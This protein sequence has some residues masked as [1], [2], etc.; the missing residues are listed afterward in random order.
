MTKQTD[1]DR[2][3]KILELRSVWGTGGGPEKTILLGAAKSNPKKYRITVC[4]IRDDRDKVF[5]P[6]NKASGL[7][8]D[9]VEIRERHSFDVRILTKLRRLCVDRRIQ[10]V[11]SH[12]Y[13]TN[14]LALLLSKL[15]HIIP[16]STAHGWTGYSRR[17]KVYYAIDKVILKYFPVVIAV[18]SQIKQELIQRGMLPEKI[19]VLLNCIDHTTHR[20]IH[21]QQLA[22]RQHLG[23]PADKFILGAVGRLEEQKCFDL[24]LEAFAELCRHHVNL[25]LAIVGDGSLHKDL[26][27]LIT[28]LNLSECCKLLGHQQDIVT[29]HHAFDMFVQSSK[30]EG[31]PNAVLEAMAMET[32]IIATNVGGTSELV[33]DGLDGLIVSQ[34]N[35]R[36]KTWSLHN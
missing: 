2:P 25:F 30:Y 19:R 5:A 16:I 11:H 1:A 10:I 8:I 28:R 15:E 14:I 35:R 32:P 36:C 20:R 34:L 17:E 24:L 22:A 23:L 27:D 21:S 33:R 3:I 13:K 26:S 12:D 9:Y 18:S 29:A 31:T 7:P 6:A 4:Y